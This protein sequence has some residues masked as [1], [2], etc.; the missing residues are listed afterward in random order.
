MQLRITWVVVKNA[1]SRA[2]L[3]IILELEVCVESTH[4]AWDQL[5]QTNEADS[6]SCFSPSIVHS[7][8]LF[9]CPNFFFFFLTEEEQ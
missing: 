7:L 9:L 1:V 3:L 5:P 2:L 4:K 6:P 8:A